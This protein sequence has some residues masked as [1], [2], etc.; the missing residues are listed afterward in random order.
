MNQ[1]E[2]ADDRSVA[3]TNPEGVESPRRPT[4][5]AISIE[6]LD[7]RQAR[8]AELLV[9][10]MPPGQVAGTIGI[11]REQ[12]WRWRTKNA[13]FKEHVHRLRMELHAA[14][15]ER[16]WTLVDKAI[17]VVDEALGEGDPVVAMQVLKLPGLHLGDAELPEPLY[18]S[19]STGIESSADHRSEDAPA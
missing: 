5:I 16:M 11:S 10:G 17:G 1:D 12:L 7:D 3:A 19:T 6:A 15:V 4:E 18:G 13:A 2:T 9:G 8:A 14:R